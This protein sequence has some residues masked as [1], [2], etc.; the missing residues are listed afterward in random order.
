MEA[1]ARKEAEE[2]ERRKQA[3][4]EKAKA[5]EAQKAAEAA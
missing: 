4:I 2:E 5:L 1:A 3:A